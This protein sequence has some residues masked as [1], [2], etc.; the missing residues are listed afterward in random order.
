MRK[1]NL[2]VEHKTI[3][4]TGKKSVDSVLVSEVS[5]VICGYEGLLGD[6]VVHGNGN[7]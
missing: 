6:I 4:T 3:A 7:M 5:H 2:E 1:E